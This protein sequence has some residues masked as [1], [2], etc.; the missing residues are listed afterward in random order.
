MAELEPI[1]AALLRALRDAGI[2]AAL[3]GGLAT[4]AWVSKDQLRV[5]YDVY[6]A[7]LIPLDM[8]FS[9]E[10]VAESI[11]SQSG[12]RCFHG[13]DLEFPKVRMIRLVTSPQGTVMDLLIADRNFTASALARTG[14]VELGGER[15]P[16][17]SPTDLVLFK[18]LGR[19][20]KDHLAI[21]SIAA[22]QKLNKRYIERW[23]RK[24]GIWGFVSRALKC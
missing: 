14:E 19:R 6:V 24:L 8:D 16:I 15:H 4:N 18:G 22:S 23:A 2:P 7:V 9:A 12:I 13:S 17:L 20:E 10:R 11:S 3:A 5:T 21:A 1:A